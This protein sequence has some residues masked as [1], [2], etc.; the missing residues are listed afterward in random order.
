MTVSL[1]SAEKSTCPPVVPLGGMVA[2]GGMW[3]WKPTAICKHCWISNTNGC[4]L[5]T[6]E[7]AVGRIN[8]LAFQGVN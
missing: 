2:M 5:Q 8:A 7:N 6:M 1:H 3:C 4:L